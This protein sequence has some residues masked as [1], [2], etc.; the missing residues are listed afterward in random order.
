[1]PLRMER[2]QLRLLGAV[3]LGYHSMARAR[4]PGALRTATDPCD[5]LLYGD[6]CCCVRGMAC[7]WEGDRH[8]SR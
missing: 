4:F 3:T 1:M 5:G 2:A 6:E 7:N 8:I